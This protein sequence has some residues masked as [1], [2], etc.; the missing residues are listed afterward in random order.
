MM[1]QA[2]SFSDDPQENLRIE[3]EFL[4]IKLKAQYGEAFKMET[5]EQLPLEIENQFLRSMMA[6]ED[7]YAKADFTTIYERIGRPVYKAVGEIR[8]FELNAALKEL[9]AI[10]EENNIG[11]DFLDGP[12]PDEVI[13][14]FITEELF[15]EEIEK[16]RVAG[17]RTN[18]IYEE[19]HPNHK[20]DIIKQTHA[21]L[22]SWFNRKF[23]EYSTE[24]S[25][26]FIT[27]DGIQMTREDVIGAM[28]IF[29]EAFYNFKDDGYNIDNVNFD[30]QETGEGMGFAEGM[31]KYDAVMDN[32]EAIRYEGPYKLYMQLEYN[33]WSIFYFVMPGFKW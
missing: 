32:G 30:L 33:W 18:F 11:L 9:T 14:R 13:Y 1:E 31:L 6:F 4:K 5:T 29:F 3:N 2:E 20:A 10:L 17:M 15:T 12:Y 8:K 19:F 25:P 23:T 7:E 26:N 24:L 28:N 27:A 22:Q 16:T 21:F